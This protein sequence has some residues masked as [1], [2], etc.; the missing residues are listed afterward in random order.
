MKRTRI[1]TSV[2][3]RADPF[4]VP[5]HRRHSAIMFVVECDQARSRR[6]NHSVHERLAVLIKSTGDIHDN[7]S[8]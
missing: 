5:K 8:N 6:G 4:L 3:A 1:Q 2:D 7:A